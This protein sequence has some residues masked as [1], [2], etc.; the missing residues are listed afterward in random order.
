VPLRVALLAPGPDGEDQRKLHPL[1]TAVDLLK[2]GVAQPAQLLAQAGE[3]IRGIVLFAP[4][5]P[6]EALVLPIGRRGDE[7]EVGEDATRCEQRVDLTE[8]GALARILEVMNPSSSKLPSTL[9]K[10]SLRT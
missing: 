9:P 8:Q 2:A 1:V 10:R 5:R 6:A 4:D 7:V 3:T